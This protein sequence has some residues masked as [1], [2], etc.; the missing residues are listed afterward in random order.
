MSVIRT[1][2]VLRPLRS[3]SRL[4]GL[5]KIIGAL[6]D[7]IEDLWNVMLLLTFF[8]FCFSTAGVVFWSGKLDARCRLTPFPVKVPGSCRSDHDP[9]WQH[10]MDSVVLDPNSH[11]CLPVANTNRSWTK[12]TSPWNI[13]GPQDCIWPVDKDDERICSLSGYGFHTCID[14]KNEQS[15]FPRICGSNFDNVGNPRFL[16]AD[17]PYG[18]PRMES[19]VFIESLNW[20]YTRFD[21]FFNAFITSFQIISMEGWTDIMYQVMDAWHIAPTIIIFVTFILVGGHIVLNLVLAVIT[22]SLDN[23]DHDGK[24]VASKK[25]TANKMQTN[26]NSSWKDNI[27]KNRM[28]ENFM[29]ICIIGNTIILG[30]DRFML[31]KQTETI[32]ETINLILNGIFFIEMI[33]YIYAFGF[34][35]YCR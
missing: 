12:S 17:E 29:M 7:S 18:F 32:L 25:E 9:C 23:L 22:G 21:T 30:M 5:K 10:F 28:F 24:N 3:L 8:L 13:Y 35:D 2:R 27:I 1:I 34:K 14:K 19:G 4:P 20:G 33:L 15:Y 16:N 26:E 11:R 31:P 6:M